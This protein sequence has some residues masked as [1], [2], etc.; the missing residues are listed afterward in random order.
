MNELIQIATIELA[1]YL[2]AKL[3]EI[4]A[5]WWQK[6][7]VERLSFQQQR[8]VQ[9]RGYHTIQQLDFAALLRVFNQNWY[10]LSSV[11][12]FPREGRTWGKELQTVRNK[13]AHLSA[14]AM[15]PGEVYRDADTLGRL[16]RMIGASLLRA[17]DHLFAQPVTTPLL[18]A[19]ALG[20]QY[21]TARQETA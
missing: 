3:P 4:S 8:M 14:E 6:H 17:L 11:L 19:S 13:W 2:S 9:E 12:S 15:P 7:V 18:L 1:E 10:E 5:D 21:V 20:I 16:L